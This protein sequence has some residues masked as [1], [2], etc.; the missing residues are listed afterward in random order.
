MS[1]LE[2]HE[3]L[4]KVEAFLVDSGMAPTR[5]GRDVMGEASLVTRLRDGR[6]LSLRNA[7]KVMR[8]IESWSPGCEAINA[9]SQRA[10]ST[11]QSG[12]KSSGVAA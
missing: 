9:A 10:G 12:E 3:L 11:G 6:S 1:L 4:A 7:N 2:D 8:F 5:F